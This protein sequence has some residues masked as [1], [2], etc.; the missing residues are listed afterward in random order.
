MT[1]DTKYLRKLLEGGDELDAHRDS[2]EDSASILLGAMPALLDAVEASQ[3]FDQYSQQ[4][5]ERYPEDLLYT[6]VQGLLTK[7]M[8]SESLASPAPWEQHYGYNNGGCPT[9]FFTIPGHTQGKKVEM[10]AEDA[11]LLVTLRNSLPV[12]IKAL[13][14]VEEARAS[15]SSLSS[16]LGSGLGGLNT[17]ISQYVERVEEGMEDHSKSLA[18]WR[19]KDHKEEA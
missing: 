12:I 17:T 14:E 11:E 7:L 1:I 2:G 19:E 3:S 16:Q 6:E 13:K 9:A 15:L 10:L 5:K 4:V 8:A 18:F